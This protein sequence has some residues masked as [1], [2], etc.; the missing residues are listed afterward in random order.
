ML[1]TDV[2]G[3]A[4]LPTVGCTAY[5]VYR[6]DSNGIAVAV[7][8]FGDLLLVGYGDIEP[9]HAAAV[10]PSKY[11]GEMRFIFNR[12]RQVGGINVVLVQEP[13]LEQRGERMRYRLADNTVDG[14][15]ASNVHGIEYL[16]QQTGFAIVI[17]LQKVIAWR[18][19]SAQIRGLH[20]QAVA[21]MRKV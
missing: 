2:V 9:G 10:Q 16:W 5:S 7:D 15:G 6:T 13:V 18:W 14:G 21:F 20:Q 1:D 11:G 8:F 3:I 12:K 4:G 17:A 19:M